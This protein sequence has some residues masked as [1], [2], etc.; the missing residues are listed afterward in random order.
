VQTDENYLD[1]HIHVD[2][3]VPM[4][5]CASVNEERG[6]NAGARTTLRSDLLY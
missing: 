6:E 3:L 5:Q 2:T 1:C 4:D